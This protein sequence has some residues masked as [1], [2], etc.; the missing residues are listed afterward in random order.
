MV[1]VSL[2]VLSPFRVLAATDRATARAQPVV[3]SLAQPS[4]SA[5]A[6]E[7]SLTGQPWRLEE[8]LGEPLPG[9]ELTPP[10]LLLTNGGELSGFGGCNYFVGKYRTGDDGGIVVSSLRASH[11]QCQELANRETTLLTS[12]LMANT[13]NLADGKLTFAMDSRRLIRL[14]KA[15]GIAVEDLIQQANQL[16]AHKKRTNKARSKKRKIASKP[17]GRGKT[18]AA[19]STGKERP[20]AKTPAKSH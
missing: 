10:F 7:T 18:T 6:V 1:M 13:V 11:R 19:R 3:A 15:P 5:V 12:L 8:L 14:S 9:E 4:A 2:L 16:K 20:V 17:K